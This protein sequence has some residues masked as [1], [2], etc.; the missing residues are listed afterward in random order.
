MLL[1]IVKQPGCVRK[2]FLKT[3]KR[4]FMTFRKRKDGERFIRFHGVTCG[5][6]LHSY[7]TGIGHRPVSVAIPNAGKVLNLDSLDR[8]FR[9]GNERAVA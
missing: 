6:A 3:Q 5:R 4:G 8:G 7:Y 1:F 9:T 2:G